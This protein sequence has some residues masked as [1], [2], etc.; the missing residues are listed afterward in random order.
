MGS[1]GGLLLWTARGDNV[2][3]HLSGPGSG[4]WGGVCVRSGFPG[5]SFLFLCVEGSLQQASLLRGSITDAGLTCCLCSLSLLFS[6]WSW[7]SS[8]VDGRAGNNRDAPAGVVYYGARVLR[9]FTGVGAV[10]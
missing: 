4:M 7:W 9:A 10:P 3:S 5:R 8:D 6:Y 2:A 1:G